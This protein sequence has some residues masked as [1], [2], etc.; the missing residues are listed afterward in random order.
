MGIVAAI[1]KRMKLG[2]RSFIGTLLLVCL[3]GMGEVYA[4]TNDSE[5]KKKTEQPTIDRSNIQAVYNSI[6]YKIDDQKDLALYNEMLRNEKLIQAALSKVT[7]L[8]MQNCCADDI[9]RL[10]GIARKLEQRNLVIKKTLQ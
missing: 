1:V 3:I 7:Y 10:N 6:P 2:F 4:Q 9:E 8:S 5:A